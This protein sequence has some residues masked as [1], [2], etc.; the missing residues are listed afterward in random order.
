[1]TFPSRSAA[2]LALMLFLISAAAAA[3]EFMFYPYYGKNKVIY[4]TFR[5]K[6]Y[7]TEHFRIHF[8]ADEPQALKNVAELS[9]SAYQKLSEI[10][11]H[12]LSDPVPL[13]YYTTFTD[14][15][16]SNVFDI[17]EGVLGVSEPLLHR[18]GIHGDMPLDELQRL[19]E[20]EL[21][22]IFEFDI[23]WGSQTAS[24]IALNVPPLW[25][26]EG[27]SEYATQD[28]SS[29]STMIVRDAVLNDR[30]PDMTESGDLE[31]RFPMP[32]DP[33]YDFGHA[34]YDFIEVRFGRNAVQDLWQSIKGSPLIRKI[35]PVKRA[36]NI[37]TLDFNQEFQKYLREKNRK[38]LLR[39]NPADYSIALGPKFPLNP[40]YFTFSHAV[41]PSGD[42]VAALTYNVSDFDVDLVLVSVEDGSIVKNITPGFT[43]K[44]EYIIYEYDPSLGSDIAWSPDGDAIA[45]IAR[46]GR[47]YSLYL[48]DPVRGV[49]TRKYQIDYDRPSA[50]RFFPDGRSV[51][52]TAFIKGT[53]D[54]FKL[55]LES[56]VTVNLTRDDYFEKAPA[57]SPD[58]LSIVYSIRLDDTDKLFLSPLADLSQKT[59]L[60]FGP[61]NT[62]CPSFSA[63]SHLV[64]YVG[65]VREAFN[66]YSVDLTK[67][68]VKRYTDVWT[69]N[70]FPSAHP[71]DP[72]KLFFSSFN[73][74][75]YQVFSARLAGTVEDRFT[76]AQLG[77]AE[78][79]RRFK[80]AL[81][82][83][84]DKEKIEPYPGL[85]ELY[86]AGRPPIDI[87]VSSDGSIYGGAALSFGDLLGDH[88][89]LVMLYQARGMTS[90]YLS[91]LN[92]KRRLQFMP[93]FYQFTMF[94]YPPYA[95]IDPSLYNRLTYQDAIAYRK[96]TSVNIDAYYPLDRYYRLE[97]NFG[98]FRYE[99]S[100]LDPY[101]LFQQG[102]G[103]GSYSY[104]WNGN[105][106]SASLALVGETTHFSPYYGP[107]AGHTFRFYL[108]QAIPVA[109]GFFSNTTVRADL[110]KYLY[111][112][113]DALLA[114]RFE[115]WAS[116]GRDPYI[117]YYG[118]NNQVRSAYFYN[119]ACTEGWFG[120]AELRLPL[121]NIA[122]TI[123]GTIGP[124]RAVFF[125]DLTRSKFYDYPAEFSLYPAPFEPAVL[126]DAIGSYGWGIQLFFLGLP[127]HIEWVK[128]LGWP[129]FANPFS[130]QSFGGFKTKFW[131]G[132]DF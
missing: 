122:S 61:G 52:F 97:G 84:I 108:A 49:I 30:L 114:L 40:Y 107:R 41:S 76:F 86:V 28:W 68:E 95:Y 39:E 90:Y 15:E 54:I 128:Q 48:V 100:F 18:I 56:G 88:N 22:H 131:I 33:S 58:G 72:G 129:D 126:L 91:Y 19:I 8:Y 77:S 29:W 36:F 23:L 10:L 82:L 12:Q 9:E 59:Q 7:P 112:G 24:L 121:I 25:L 20:H 62:T 104:F 74:G 102:V 109:A 60:T 5:W 111:L 125:F 53:H 46:D 1:M 47:R 73:K 94:Y 27:L 105:V 132:L 31:S 71:A 3:Q 116:R 2:R 69:G 79:L 57:V 101:D 16:L 34:I 80:P 63:D 13:I 44:Y 64:Y 42:L 110:R 4:E 123:I 11:K 115:G 70:F 78:P 6:T 66:I 93:T 45:F 43:T 113:S 21:A 38:Y 55:D 120:N 106:L 14:F 83:D 65:D 37:K 35:A 99:E 85:N 119:I 87:L 124:I 89:F 17:S 130:I 118:G 81:T 92:Q 67:G 75:S 51:L 50:P 98:F 32:R 26:F 117:S 127:I 103:P 96:I